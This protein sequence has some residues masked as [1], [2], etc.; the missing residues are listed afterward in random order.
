MKDLD[1]IQRQLDRV[2]GFFP[3]VEARINALFGVN[4]LILIIAALNVSAGDLQ[5]WYVTIPGSLLLVGLLVSYYH[6]F[7][8]NFPDDNG[9]EKSLIFFKEIQ[10]RTEANYIAEFHECS[11]ATLRND[12]LGQIWRNSC[13]VCEKYRRVKLAI[14]ACAMSVA[15]FVVFLVITGAIH[16]RIPMLGG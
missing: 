12:L 14:I 2:L 6:L 9:G 7:R 13:I 10:K 3:R 8:A 4:T 1:I 11:E 16:S 15:P 5:L